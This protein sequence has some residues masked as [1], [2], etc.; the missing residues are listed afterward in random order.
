MQ[1]PS[2]MPAFKPSLKLSKPI[3]RLRRFIHLQGNAIGDAGEQA[4]QQIMAYVSRNWLEQLLQRIRANDPSC[5]K[6]DLSGKA[7]GAVGA[8]ALAEG[9]QNQYLSQGN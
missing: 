8:Q 2:E 4:V 5:T 9:T 3:P 7:I 6:I 1:T